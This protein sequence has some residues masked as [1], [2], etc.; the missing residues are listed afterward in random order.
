MVVAYLDDDGMVGMLGISGLVA[1]GDSL[2]SLWVSQDWLVQKRVRS[3][4]IV[5]DRAF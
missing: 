1:L 5:N 2:L 3:D 4:H